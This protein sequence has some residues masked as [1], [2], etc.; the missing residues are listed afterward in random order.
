MKNKKLDRV[1]FR[2]WGLSEK[3][4]KVYTN[5]SFIFFV[6]TL[7]QYYFAECPQSTPLLIGNKEDLESF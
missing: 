7:G 4:Y 6:D 3:A 2:S 1:F 5:I